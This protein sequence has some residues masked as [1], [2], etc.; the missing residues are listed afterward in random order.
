MRHL[1]MNDLLLIFTKKPE[2]GK[3][4]TRLSKTI[5]DHRALDIYE[6]LLDYTATFSTHV[7]A[8]KHVYFSKLYDD[9]TRWND[10]QF[11]K[12]EQ[13]D[14]DL[15][16]KMKD[17]FLNSFQEGY[18]KVVIIGSDCAAINEHDIHAAFQALSKNDAVIGPALDGGYYLLGMRQPTPSLFEDKSWSTTILMDET[19]ASL[20]QGNHSY[21]LLEK[22][23]DIDYEED[24]HRDSYI[25]FSSNE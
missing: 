10:K 17:A 23:S 16:Q 7:K 2:L 11:Y 24:L 22:K 1:F 8:D 19:I 3:C 6:Q 20:K 9:D 5:G 18:S 21:I 4:K 14:G 25:D 15:G 12:R 13:I